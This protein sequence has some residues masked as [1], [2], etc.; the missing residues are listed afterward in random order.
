M[1]PTSIQATRQPPSSIGPTSVWAAGMIGVL[2]VPRPTESFATYAASMAVASAG[3]LWLA[4]RARNG[5]L[6]P[7]AARTTLILAILAMLVSLP[8]HPGLSGDVYRYLYEGRVVWSHGP[9]FPFIHAP[10]EA[11]ALGVSELVRGELWARINHPEIPTIYPPLAQLTFAVAG[12]LALLLGTNG[13]VILKALLVGAAGIA[14]AAVGRT[15]AHRAEALLVLACPV[16][17]V[18]TA[19]EGHADSLAVMGLAI[20]AAAFVGAA[21]RVGHAGFALAALSKLNGLIALLAA[22]RATRRGLAWSV[23]LCA[24]L[25]VPFLLAGSDAGQGLG[26]YAT[27]WRAGDGAFSIVLSASEL[28]LG[29]DWRRFGDV[30]VTRHQVARI[31]VAVIWLVCAAIVL[32][33]PLEVKRVPAVA[34]LLLLLVLLFAPTLHPWYSLWLLPLIP[35]ADT[36]RRAMLALVALSSINHHAVWIEAATGEWSEW[37]AARALVHVPVWALLLYDLGRRPRDVV[38]GR[39]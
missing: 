16:L 37:A 20:G 19:R 1:N 11:P 29:G 8:T 36:G 30:T 39:G 34:G 32:R 24:L 5:Q 28:A 2:A 7:V 22:T 31:A 35:F 3:W 13:L 18:E 27:R 33:R 10:S 17:I 38:D 12:G 15:A 14:A 23:G 4:Q 9:A 25:A 6:S 21:P 26:A